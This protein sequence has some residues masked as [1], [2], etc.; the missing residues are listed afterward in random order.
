MTWKERFV[1]YNVIILFAFALAAPVLSNGYRIFETIEW[2]VIIASLLTGVTLFGLY[3]SDKREI[4]TIL[5][6]VIHSSCK[7]NLREYQRLL[8]D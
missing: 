5:D 2:I 8:G 6:K 4:D 3:K 7:I 1:M